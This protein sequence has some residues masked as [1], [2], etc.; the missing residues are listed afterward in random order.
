MSATRVCAGPRNSEPGHRVQH[1]CA[2]PG[3]RDRRRQRIEHSRGSGPPVPREQTASYRSWNVRPQPGRHP[4]LQ[5]S[6]GVANSYRSHTPLGRHLDR[7]RALGAQT[8]R[9]HCRPAG[10]I[11]RCDWRVSRSGSPHSQSDRTISSAARAAPAALSTDSAPPRRPNTGM[12][13][14]RRKM[15]SIPIRPAARE[16]SSARSTG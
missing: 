15:S 2:D 6:G 4:H 13:R 14:R 5:R 10:T 11:K 8:K 3:R 16:F 1:R 9:P 12:T 7:R